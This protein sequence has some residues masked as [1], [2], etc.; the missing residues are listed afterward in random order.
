VT[1]PNFLGIGVQRAG[2]TWLYKLLTGHPEVFMPSTRKEVRFFDRYYDRG[3][4]WYETFFCSPE[5][6]CKYKAIG[7]ISSQY[8]CSKGCPGR[9]FNLIPEA[10]LII[11]LRHPVTRAYSQ[12]GFVVQRRNFKGSFEEYLDTQ[13]KS[14]E[15]GFYSGYLK[16]YLKYYNRS[17]ILALLFED[18]TNDVI[19]T[20]NK[21]SDFLDIQVNKFPPGAGRNKVNPSTMPKYQ[22]L[23]GFGSKIVRQLRR[24]NLEQIVD[25]VMRTNIQRIL[26]K[27]KSLPP[28]D[29]N[30]KA[31]LSQLFHEDFNEIERCMQ[32]DLSAWRT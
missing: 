27:G 28:L 32:I 17:Q 11:I 22:F 3:I 24:W 23:Y 18:A 6:A 14:L 2:T 16:K 8:Y 29:K 15:K 19:T 1:L 9:I 5:D 12:Y 4:D 26:R 7:E 13:P 30:F 31:E 25:L 21:L 20:K 10:K